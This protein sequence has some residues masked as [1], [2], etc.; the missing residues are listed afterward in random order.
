MGT[1]Q[2][3]LAAVAAVM[4]GAGLNAGGDDAVSEDELECLAAVLIAR[5]L[6]RGY[7]SHKPLVL[8]LAKEN[9]FPRIAGMPGNWWEASCR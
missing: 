1:A 3:R 2:L 7:L 4:R 5:K 8:V 6:V 9:P